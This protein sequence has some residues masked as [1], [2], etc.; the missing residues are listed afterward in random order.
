M[1][2][3]G[4]ALVHGVAVEVAEDVACSRST[5]MEGVHSGRR[6]GGGPESALMAGAVDVRRIVAKSNSCTRSVARLA[7]AR[8]TALISISP[9]ASG[10]RQAAVR[11]A[12]GRFSS[13]PRAAFEQDAATSADGQPAPHDPAAR[14]APVQ[15]SAEIRSGSAD[16]VHGHLEERSVG[17][18]LAVQAARV[19]LHLIP[20]SQGEVV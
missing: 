13:T 12:R 4:L 17:D 8:A 5:S 10:I 2:A 14:A 20:A 15:G 7:A 1:T 3:C 16:F 11:R 19:E 6:R 9:R 18:R